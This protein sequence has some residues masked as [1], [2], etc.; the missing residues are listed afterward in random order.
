MAKIFEEPWWNFGVKGGIQIKSSGT[1][2]LQQ[3]GIN[4][5]KNPYTIILL[6]IRDRKVTQI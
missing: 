3:V 4:N 6:R 5:G 2:R 1:P